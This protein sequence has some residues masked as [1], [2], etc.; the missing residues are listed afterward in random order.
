MSFGITY[1]ALGVKVCALA[2]IKRREPL[3]LI[4]DKFEKSAELP[5][6]VSA[7]P[8]VVMVRLP[9]P[10]RFATVSLYAPVSNEPEVMVKSFALNPR[11]LQMTDPVLDFVILGN[12]MFA[13]GVNVCAPDP[14]NSSVP[15]PAITLILLKSVVP[16][17][18]SVDDPKSTVAPELPI[19]LIT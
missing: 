5:V 10:E 6:M 17:D 4:E 11:V 15:V 3:A 18:C 7:P 14:E 13:R 2:P 1:P 12:S 9:A 19:I 16:V 8:A